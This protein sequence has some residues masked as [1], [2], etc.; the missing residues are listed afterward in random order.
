[1]FAPILILVLVLVLALTLIILAPV[2]KR[3]PSSEFIQ[4]LKSWEGK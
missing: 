4:H 3:F 2:Q 1:M